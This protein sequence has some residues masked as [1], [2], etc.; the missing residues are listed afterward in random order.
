MG[1]AR[2]REDAVLNGIKS[3]AEQMAHGDKIQL[4]AEQAVGLH[5]LDR[6]MTLLNL[7]AAQLAEVWGQREL[8]GEIA[9]AI[10][11]LNKVRIRFVAEAQRKVIVPK[12]M[13]SLK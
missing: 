5:A 3:V 12:P 9:G 8:A 13:V 2:Q 6:V 4:T 1:E 10:E 7:E 11:H